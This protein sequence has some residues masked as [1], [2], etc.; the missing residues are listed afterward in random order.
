M[1]AC[2]DGIHGS[3]P[4]S[5]LVKMVSDKKSKLGVVVDNIATCVD[6][7]GRTSGGGHDNLTLAVIETKTNSK[8]KIKMSKQTKIVMAGLIVLLFMSVALNIFQLTGT[9]GKSSENTMSNDTVLNIQST[10]NTDSIKNNINNYK[11]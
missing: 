6:N 11:K 8:L 2:S 3:M 5:E 9:A 7:I 1:L 4:E 10:S